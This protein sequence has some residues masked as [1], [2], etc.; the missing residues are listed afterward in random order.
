MA[1][2]EH[3]AILK[4]GVETWNAWREVTWR[5]A[6][7]SVIPDLSE[8]DFSGTDLAKANLSGAILTNTIFTEADLEGAYLIKT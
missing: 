1:N 5:E 6:N 7:H 8:A 2:P 4:Q 3:V